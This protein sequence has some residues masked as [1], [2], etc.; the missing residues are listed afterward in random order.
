MTALEVP[1]MSGNAL[2]PRCHFPPS[3]KL[4]THY[5]LTKITRILSSICFCCM[6]VERLLENALESNRSQAPILRATIWLTVIVIFGSSEELYL[7]HGLMCKLKRT[8]KKQQQRLTQKWESI[9]KHLII[10]A[11]VSLCWRKKAKEN[12]GLS[13]IHLSVCLTD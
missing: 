10:E 13:I 3:A 2:L 7:N 9:I 12:T 8:A 6:D 11:F 1:V 4:S 5:T